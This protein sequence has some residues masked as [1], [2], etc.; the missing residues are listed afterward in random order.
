[1]QPIP[2]KHK[3]GR[4]IT[5]GAVM[6]TGVSGL[7]FFAGY[8]TCECGRECKVALDREYAEALARRFTRRPNRRTRLLLRLVAHYA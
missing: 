1:M 7:K 5:P 2:A 6:T 8:Y 4:K 3:S